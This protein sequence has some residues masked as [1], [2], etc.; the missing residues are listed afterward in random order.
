MNVTGSNQFKDIVIQN[1]VMKP[2]K[3]SQPTRQT[4]KAE[5]KKPGLS[6]NIGSLV[7]LTVESG[8][9]VK[10]NKKIGFAQANQKIK[11]NGSF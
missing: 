4:P 9:S 2:R 5:I 1:G 11:V 7:N 3:S 8:S 6:R 10:G